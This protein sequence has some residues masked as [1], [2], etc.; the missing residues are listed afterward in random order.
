M[1]ASLTADYS[2]GNNV[3]LSYRGGWHQSNTTNQQ[4]APPDSS[5]Y[6]FN[7]SNSIYSADPFYV[8]NPDLIQ[9]TG[10][11]NSALYQETT[12]YLRGKIG[13]N[14]DGTFYF[15]AGGEHAVKLGV[16][17]NYIYEDRFTG[18]PHPRVYLY[19]GQ[20]TNDLDFNIGPAADPETNPDDIYGAYGYYIV[21]SSFTS[22][23][24]SVW[25]I[26]SNN[27]SVYAQDS[28]TIK[29]RLTLN[30]GAPGREPVHADLHG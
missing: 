2:L 27:L 9:T 29:N 23:Y 12:K 10:W 4:I 8:T 3:L 16:G 7:T 30:F 25:K 22:A 1:S 19:W 6:Q 28:W 21:R 17:Y 14:I 24:G 5:T 15:N 20:T 11:T 18:A 13:N 26:K